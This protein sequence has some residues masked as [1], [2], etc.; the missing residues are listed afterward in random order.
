MSI[1]INIEQ[2][3]DFLCYYRSRMVEFSVSNPHHFE[4]VYPISIDSRLRIYQRFVEFARNESISNQK[5]PAETG[6]DIIR[7]GFTYD[8]L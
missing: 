5:R 3:F 7:K 4:T 8:K 6:L 1:F 2:S